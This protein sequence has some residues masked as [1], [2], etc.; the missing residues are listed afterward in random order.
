MYCNDISNFSTY[1]VTASPSLFYNSFTQDV[2]SKYQS[3]K[4]QVIKKKK[5]VIKMKKL[6]R[7]SSALTLS[8]A[9]P[10]HILQHV[11]IP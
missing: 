3:K 11:T 5:K 1:N 7:R 10:T 8:A 4:K 6:I 9:K 2:L